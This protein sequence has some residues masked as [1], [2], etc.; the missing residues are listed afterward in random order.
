MSGYVINIY[1]IYI[2]AMV[3]I[4]QRKVISDIILEDLVHN[5]YPDFSDESVGHAQPRLNE[6]SR[7]RK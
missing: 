3:R 2:L 7:L 1:V 6:S 5:V 4:T